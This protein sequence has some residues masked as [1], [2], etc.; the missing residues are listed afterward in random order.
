[1]IS[2]AKVSSIAINNG[3][4][5]SGPELQLG[6]HHSQVSDVDSPRRIN[7]LEDKLRGTWV[8]EAVFDSGFVIPAK[9]SSRKIGM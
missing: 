9:G 6:R 8:Y 3:D 7:F 4:L 2:I 5:A 1:L